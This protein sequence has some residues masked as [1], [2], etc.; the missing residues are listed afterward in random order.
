[1]LHVI[2]FVAT[3]RGDLQFFPFAE[4]RFFTFCDTWAT[5]NQEKADLFAIRLANT[6]TL[7]DNTVPQDIENNLPINLPNTKQVEKVKLVTPSEIRKDTILL[8]N[9]KVP[10][11]C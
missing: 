1:M 5:T 2:P 8:N 11:K 10:A 6:F 4:L 7:Q 9:K 3:F